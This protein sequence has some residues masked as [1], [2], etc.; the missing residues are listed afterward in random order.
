MFFFLQP[1]RTVRDSP[2][3]FNDDD[4]QCF[5]ARLAYVNVPLSNTYCTLSIS[6]HFISL[7]KKKKWFFFFFFFF[8]FG[9]FFFCWCSVLVVNAQA[10][11]PTAPAP[12]EGPASESATESPVASEPAQTNAPTDAVTT[13]R[14]TLAPTTTTKQ[15]TFTAATTKPLNPIDV[16][17][18]NTTELYLTE[19]DLRIGLGIGLAGFICCIIGIVACVINKRQGNPSRPQA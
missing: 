19:N 13:S 10:P 16:A 8:F 7:R 2:F 9:L 5:V 17:R 1:L 6:T 11:E 12:T 18:T 4:A 14:I 15:T 3:D